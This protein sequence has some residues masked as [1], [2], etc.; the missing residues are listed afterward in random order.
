MFVCVFVLQRPDTPVE[1]SEVVRRDSFISTD[2]LDTLRLS[3]T[4]V[5][6]VRAGSMAERAGLEEGFV[7]HM[8]NRD[9]IL[10]CS[11]EQMKDLVD[12]W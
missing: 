11:V 10:R 5:G 12:Q 3:T 2:S 1:Q 6:K 8:I 4:F 9:S 7:V